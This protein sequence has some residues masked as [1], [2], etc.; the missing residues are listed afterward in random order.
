[1]NLIQETLEK[2]EEI[3]WHI[4]YNVYVSVRENNPC[5][6]IR[7]YRKP[8]QDESVPTKK[9]YAFDLNNMSI[10][11]NIGSQLKMPFRN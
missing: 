8:Q 7:Q 11:R 10:W 1:M 3:N 2:N 6:E 5:V 4:G 9:V